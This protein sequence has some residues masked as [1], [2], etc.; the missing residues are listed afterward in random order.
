MTLDDVLR[1][2]DALDDCRTLP[3]HI[4][5]KGDIVATVLRGQELGWGPMASLRLLSNIRGKEVIDAAGQLGLMK[6]KAGI[7]FVWSQTD[8]DA[9][10]LE[11]TV[12]GKKVPA[13]S[14]TTADA[15]RAGLGGNTWSKHTGAMLRARCV[16]KAAKMY[17]P[18]VLA[19]CYV[20]GEI[21]SDDEVVTSAS[22]VSAQVA[23]GDPDMQELLDKGKDHHA[24]SEEIYEQWKKD[25]TDLVKKGDS[26]NA[27]R[28]EL[29]ESWCHYHG[30]TLW[31]LDRKV[32]RK[33][34]TLLK[35]ACKALEADLELMT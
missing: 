1:L 19:G 24:A 32:Q 17:A 20:P 11:L 23:E 30:T 35:R 31:L 3:D 28:R 7:S 12:D 14:F 29:L 5:T 9:A 10:V 15:K 13:V 21:P 27:A 2:A 22:S 34:E 6:T 26:D 33:F 16:S 25:L 8:N 18:H 4:K